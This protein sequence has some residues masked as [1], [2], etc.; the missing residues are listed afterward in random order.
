V[1]EGLDPPIRVEFA[2][3]P[4]AHQVALT[5]PVA[6]ERSAQALND[7][8]GI[9]RRMTDRIQQTVVSMPRRPSETEVSFG[10]KFDAEAG[11]II[12]KAGVEA[13][14]NVLF[15]WDAVAKPAADAGE[16][17]TAEPASI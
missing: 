5:G 17:D 1:A 15:R 11:A 9:I 16:Q 12:A 3:G 6:L 14:I 2:H 8:M 10:I 4:G 7:A 13:A